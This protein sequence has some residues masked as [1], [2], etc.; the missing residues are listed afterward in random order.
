MKIITFLLFLTILSNSSI[1]QNR[2]TISSEI[3]IEIQDSLKF[4]FDN[5]G[6]V[7]NSTQF[8]QP[9]MCRHVSISP[10]DTIA[11]FFINYPERIKEITFHTDQRGSLSANLKLTVIQA[12]NFKNILIDWYSIDSTVLDPILFEGSGENHPVFSEVYIKKESYSSEER[13]LL[14]AL[15]NRIVIILKW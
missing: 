3:K 10:Y 2:D 5:P 1:G 12:S 9:C 14:Y 11:S 7:Y 15:N 8:G 6:C 4:V 13:N